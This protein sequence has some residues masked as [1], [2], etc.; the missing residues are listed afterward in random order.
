MAKSIRQKAEDYLATF[1]GLE[2]SLNKVLATDPASW[3]D[4]DREN[5][6]K[7][8]EILDDMGKKIYGHT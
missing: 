1:H 3:R 7:A 6:A 5:V 2:Y 8:K 4:V